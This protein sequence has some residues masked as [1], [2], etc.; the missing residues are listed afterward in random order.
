MLVNL[1]TLIFER[2]SSPTTA[3]LNMLFIEV[4]PLK[5][6]ELKSRLSKLVQFANIESNEDAKENLRNEK[7]N[8]VTLAQSANSFP[9]S[10]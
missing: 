3:P 10:Y 6:N 9:Q 5:S 2:L 7:S 1:V 8:L 4:T